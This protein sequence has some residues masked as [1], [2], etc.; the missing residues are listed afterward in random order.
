MTV[1]RT[2]PSLRRWVIISILLHAGL[3]LLPAQFLHIFFPREMPAMREG[4]TR[5]PWS[6]LSDMVMQVIPI[7][8]ER[9]P[10]TVDRAV[11]EI[12]E[13][14]PAPT[15]TR[16]P[17]TPGGSPEGAG[18]ARADIPAGNVE[19]QFFPPV[20]RFIVPPT[21]E[22]L[23]ISTIEVNVRILVSAKGLPRRVIIEDTLENPEVRERVLESAWRFRF[24]A[25]KLGYTPVESWIDLPLVLEATGSR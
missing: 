2:H 20:P 3:V 23:G 8:V 14:V 4:R 13:E 10:E 25:A 22:D 9:T 24:E 18:I 12:V 21:L 19:P 6:G 1:K 7:E 5:D 15:A 11:L 16:E 17:A